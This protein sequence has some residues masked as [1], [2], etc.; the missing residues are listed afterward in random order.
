MSYGTPEWQSWV[1][2]EKAG[3][4]HIKAAYEAGI[5]VRH[6]IAIYHH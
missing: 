5:N 6:P 2:G 3:F 1:L 4:E